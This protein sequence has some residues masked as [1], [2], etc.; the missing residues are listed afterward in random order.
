M[1]V[2]RPALAL[3]AAASLA[4]LSGCAAAATPEEQAA[5]EMRSFV[6]AI[7]GDGDVKL[8][9]ETPASSGEDLGGW[10][11]LDDDI[12]VSA[13]P[14]PYLWE[15]RAKTQLI[16]GDERVQEQSIHVRL[17]EDGEPCV[18]NIYG[19]ADITD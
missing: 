16:G 17:P 4:L 15:V 5:Q 13:H 1:N 10:K 11:I 14:E 7:N 6:D 18:L 2:T 8:C 9:P 3:A 19:F 12:T